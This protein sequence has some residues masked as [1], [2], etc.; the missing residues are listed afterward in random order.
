MRQLYWG[1]C[2]RGRSQT[3]LVQS[4]M[5]PLRMKSSVQVGV[6]GVGVVLDAEDNPLI[7]AQVTPGM[8]SLTYQFDQ[9]VSAFAFSRGASTCQSVLP[10]KGVLQRQ[11]RSKSRTEG[12]SWKR[13]AITA[14]S[15]RGVGLS[16]R[17][18]SEGRLI[19]AFLRGGFG[20]HHARRPFC[21]PSG[22][23][24][25]RRSSYSSSWRSSWTTT[26]SGR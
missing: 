7:P 12:S 5:R 8:S 25:A 23:Y 22:G 26:H 6:L 18:P 15:S 1:S 2:R 19:G 3:D 14:V 17:E 24:H 13:Q 10:P 4:S 16:P 9:P 20:D 11:A 21:R